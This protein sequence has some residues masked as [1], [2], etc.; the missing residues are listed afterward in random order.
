VR[1]GRHLLWT[2]PPLP[3]AA[4]SPG[5]GGRHYFGMVRGFAP[6]AGCA[7]ALVVAGVCFGRS[8]GTQWAADGLRWPFGPGRAKSNLV[9][10]RMIPAV[11]RVINVEKIRDGGS[12]A[13]RFASDGGEYILFIKLRCVFH[14]LPGS[15]GQIEQLGFDQPFLIDCD[16]KKRPAD[17]DEV[18]YS[19]LSGPAFLVSWGE[20][21]ELLC[22]ISGLSAGLNRLKSDWL[23]EMVNAASHEGRVPPTAA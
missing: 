3:T 23:R 11:H 18:G 20:A 10:E 6:M 2:V 21:R 19:E 16:P 9:S 13:A 5:Y 17:T 12:L 22:A 1:S 4:D 8:A 14:G 7:A 15:Q